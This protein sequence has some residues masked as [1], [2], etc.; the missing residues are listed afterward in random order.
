VNTASAL[1]AASRRGAARF[2]R[3]VPRVAEPA[4]PGAS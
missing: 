3:G 4:A 2:A 1:P